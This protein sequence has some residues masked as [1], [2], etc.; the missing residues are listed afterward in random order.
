MFVT[1][2]LVIRRGVMIRAL[3]L[4]VEAHRFFYWTR[5]LRTNNLLNKSSCLTVRPPNNADLSVHDFNVQSNV[6]SNVKFCSCSQLITQKVIIYFDVEWN[7][8]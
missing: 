7:F 8:S 1:S 6:Q 5:K 3:L 4:V 2:S